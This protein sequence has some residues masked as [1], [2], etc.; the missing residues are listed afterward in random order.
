MI[1]HK[2]AQMMLL[3]QNTLKNNLF[4]RHLNGGL[5]RRFLLLGYFRCFLCF[6]HV[7][8]YLYRLFFDLSIKQKGICRMSKSNKTIYYNPSSSIKLNGQDKA[9][10]N[11][12]PFGTSGYYNMDD[13]EE[14]AY[15]YAGEQFALNLP[16]LNVF[17][18]DTQRKFDNQ[19]Q[20]YIN[21][22]VD[23]INDIY[24]PMLEDL[25][26]DIASRF[27]NLDNSIF[28]DNLEKI[29]NS[30]ADAVSALSQDVQTYRQDLINNELANRYE[31]LN[32]LNNY[33][34]QLLS[35]A[36]EA[37]GASQN[38]SNLSNS[39]YSNLNQMAGKESSGFNID[40]DRLLDKALSAATIFTTL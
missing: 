33:R 15:N 30:R 35:N 22:G 16:E 34:Q 10:I 27:G 2:I 8:Y 19:V 31:Y 9:G 3:M 28:M 39:Y 40:Y 4:I 32:Y 26:N 11:V 20:S 37:L 1:M 38:L 13:S 5:N 24:T 14:K 7:L 25:Q 21:Q 17:D 29:E 23:D 6:K 18:A 36:L 12:S